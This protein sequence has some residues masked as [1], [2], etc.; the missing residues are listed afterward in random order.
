MFFKNAV[1]EK[2]RELCPSAGSEAGSGGWSYASKT[3][4]GLDT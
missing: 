3:N 1:E 2:L 4:H